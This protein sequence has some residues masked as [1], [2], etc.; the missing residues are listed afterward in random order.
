MIAAQLFLVYLTVPFWHST[1]VQSF[2]LMPSQT[3]SYGLV[4]VRMCRRIERAS[5][6]QLNLTDEGSEGPRKETKSLGVAVNDLAQ[7]LKPEAQKAAVESA[8]AETTAKK[9][10][11]ALKSYCCYMLFILYRSYRGIF[12]LSPAVFRRVYSKLKDAIDT[13][14]ETDD[15]DLETS[16]KASVRTRITVSILAGIVTFSYFLGGAI[17]VIGKF[18]RTIVNTTS[19]SKSF[20]AAVDELADHEGRVGGY[21]KQNF[22][23]DS[24]AP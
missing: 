16:K 21:R 18:F 23:G 12:V 5:L 15:M 7:S 1:S 2:Q 9:I 17:R 6:S 24:S 11:L 22:N 19:A 20:E 14:L 13:D 4:R 3:Q 8:E 10:L